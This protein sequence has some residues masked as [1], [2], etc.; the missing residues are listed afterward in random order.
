M[1][2]KTIV[3]SNEELA[4]FK[5]LLVSLTEPERE[6]REVG[7]DVSRPQLL[8]IARAA[9]V[10]RKRR[11]DYLHRAMLGEP[12]YDMML[13]LYVTEGEG[14]WVTASRIAEIA[15]VAPSS[16][17]R[18]IEYLVTK[19]LIFREPHPTHK[20]ASVLKLTGKGKEALEGLFRTMLE[21]YR[22]LSF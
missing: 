1:P 22:D 4:S 21:G 14:E 3:L 11:A 2:T 7:A 16:A 17:S 20:R 9:L 18:W 12:A 6:P 10:L 15:A 19:Q 5:R 8:K 13:G